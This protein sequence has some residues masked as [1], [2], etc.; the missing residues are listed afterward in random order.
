MST[1]LLHVI[2]FISVAFPPYVLYVCFDTGKKGQRRCRR[3]DISTRFF[4]TQ[5]KNLFVQAVTVQKKKTPSPNCYHPWAMTNHFDRIGF[6]SLTHARPGRKFHIL[7][8]QDWITSLTQ[9]IRQHSL[10]DH[11]YFP[12]DIAP[13][14]G[15]GA[16]F[17]RTRTVTETPQTSL[18]FAF[19]VLFFFHSPRSHKVSIFLWD[20]MQ[21]SLITT[22]AIDRL[23]KIS[24]NNYHIA[25][26]T[27]EQA[28]F[29]NKASCVI[30]SAVDF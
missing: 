23:L 14:S 25:H 3:N 22:H 27:C 30:S 9:S 7:L 1:T 6:A 24:L 19:H 28:N 4:K 5:K 15:R 17:T 18:R 21:I 20:F 13:S 26:A 29:T 10:V 8:A 16:S 11:F 12:F 2:L